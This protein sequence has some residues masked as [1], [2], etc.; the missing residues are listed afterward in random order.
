MI[1]DV[2][3]DGETNGIAALVTYTNNG[4]RRFICSKSQNNKDQEIRLFPNLEVAKAVAKTL[5]NIQEYIEYYFSIDG[6]MY[7]LA[8]SHQ[9]S[10]KKWMTIDNGEIIRIYEDTAN[11]GYKFGY[12]VF[13]NGDEKQCDKRYGNQRQKELSKLICDTFKE[14]I[15][16]LNLTDDFGITSVYK[17]KRNSKVYIRSCTGKIDVYAN[18]YLM[19][20][21]QVR[22]E[23]GLKVFPFIKGMDKYLTFYLILSKDITEPIRIDSVE[24][25]EF[26][27]SQFEQKLK[28]EYPELN[29]HIKF[30]DYNGYVVF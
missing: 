5:N 30:I 27:L 9:L 4:N 20:T 25:T 2:Y 11:K 15:I 19:D 23:D 6:R 24:R 26:V 18:S 28:E 16:S 7:S 12:I 17:F 3:L 10:Y 14:L 1:K 8:D 29:P 13:E 21:N 22:K